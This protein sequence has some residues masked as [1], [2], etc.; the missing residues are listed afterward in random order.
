M[1]RRRLFVSFRHLDAI[2]S[3]CCAISSDPSYLRAFQRRASAYESLGDIQAALQDLQ[4][5]VNSDCESSSLH[6]EAQVKIEEL[7]R[8]YKGSLKM[9][10]Y[11]VLG[12][13]LSATAA[14]VKSQFRKLALQFH[15]DKTNNQ[16]GSAE[17][18]KLISQANSIL[19]DESKRRR[20]DSA[21]LNNSRFDQHR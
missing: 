19:S 14:E 18:F 1:P 21:R 15:P 2:V 13:G 6:R 8:P 10:P 5:I 9:D 12:L 4:W 17:V 7:Q 16:E 20:F 3:S 11:K